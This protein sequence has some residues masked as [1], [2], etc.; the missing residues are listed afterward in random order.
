MSIEYTR[1]G[2]KVGLECHQQLDTEEKLFCACKPSLFKEEPETV[3]MRRLRPTQS[4]MGQVDPAAYFE[5]KKEVRILYESNRK[6]ACLVEMDEEPPHELNREALD[7]ALSIALMM[8]AKPVDE[9]HVMRKI[10]ID[11]SNTTGFQRTCVIALNGSVEVEGKRVPIEHI[12]LEEDAAR[13]ISDEGLTVRYRIDRLCIPL[14]EVATGPVITTPEEAQK[15]ALSIGRIL[16]A[17]GKVKRGIGTIRQDLNISISEGA[18]VE[19]KGVQELELISKVVEYEVQRQLNLLKIRDEL[20]ARGLSESTINEEIIDVTSAFKGTGCRLIGRAIDQGKHVL[21]VKL[22]K[23]SGLL[24]LEL[25]P[26]V[27]LGTEMADRARFWGR[28]AGILHSDEFQKYGLTEK[29]VAEVRRLLNAEIDDAVVIVADSKENAVDALGAVIERAREAI[30]GVPEETRA[31]NPDGT[32][33]YMRPRP[34][35]ARMY[36]ETDVPPIEIAAEYVERIRMNLPELPEERIRRL[37]RDYGLNEKLA[38]QLQDSPYGD[39]FEKIMKETRIAPTVVA[40]TLTET[41][42]ALK[43]EGAEIEQLNDA[44]LIEL[45]KLVDAKRVSKESIPEIL[46]WLTKHVD[47]KPSEAVDALGLSILS[48]AEISSIIDSIIEDKREIIR[49]KGAD[50]FSFLMGTIMREYRGKVDTDSLSRMIKEKLS[51]LER[52]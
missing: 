51:M 29:E 24:G 19:I 47:L 13:K 25:I 15:V 2:L 37:M 45:F 20:R 23:F 22:P 8:N 14:I 49:G 40:A 33:R 9:V 38:R 5:F 31:A 21:A 48:E 32:T 34:G 4:E 42:K 39:L 27:R 46:R 12:S 18:L 44:Q 17:T 43:R 36:P 1:I 26:G 7:I 50:A 30:K 6:A 11:G 41:L 35:A 10:V 52:E 28:V 16:R 3:F